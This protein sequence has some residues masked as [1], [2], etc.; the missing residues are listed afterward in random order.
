MSRVRDL[1]RRIAE[2]EAIVAQ[3]AE[4]V[5]SLRSENEALRAETTEQAE[6][7]RRL[8]HW[9]FGRKTE[10]SAELDEIQELIP[11]EGWASDLLQ[12]ELEPVVEVPEGAEDT[13]ANGRGSGV[14]PGAPG[15]RAHA[16]VLWSRLC[17][18]LRVVEEL[19]E[20]PKDTLF[21]DDGTPLVR[22]GTETREELV[23]ENTLPYIRRVVRQRYGRSDTAEKVAIAGNPNRIVP[24][25]VLADETIIN[26]VVALGSDCLPF[27][28][29]AEQFAR[30]GIPVTRQTLCA[31]FHVWCA[32]ASPLV[33]AMAA[34]ITT[35][36]MVHVDGSF[37][38]RQNRDC[39]RKCTRFP[40]YAIS[41]GDQVVLRWRPNEKHATAADLLRGYHGYLIRDE[42]DGWWKLED[43]DVVHVGCNAHARR[44]FARNQE[45]R[46]C[47][48]MVGLYAKLAAVEKHAQ[49]SGLGGEAL[50]AHRSRLRSEHSRAIM[51]AIE[52]HARDIIGRRT[53]AIVSSAKYIL[54]HRTELRR[55]LDNGALPPD[56][57][58]AERVLRRNALIRRNRSFY[59]AEDGGINLAHA[60]SVCGSCRLLGINPIDYLK[61]SLPALLAYR[62]AITDG[63]TLP[64]LSPWTPAAYAAAISSKQAAA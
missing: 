31:S 15:K 33:D 63:T 51:D 60:M 35:A 38:Y 39:S 16:R 27:Y 43:V 24:R 26:A 12:H 11:L 4:L 25:G 61:H 41:D 22:Q 8:L 46:D 37:I 5:E 64:S 48:Y 10:K 47:A 54:K 52:D 36:D 28:R 9:R 3:Q 18:H 49:A 14:K 1:E 19:H 56:N 6:T 53:G 17:P 21:D 13:G 50:F 57:N 59:V 45:D 44:Y 34:Q 62:A 42:W 32:L 30:L 55:F 23:Y 29:Q 58:L 7:I 2:L 20:L 40:V